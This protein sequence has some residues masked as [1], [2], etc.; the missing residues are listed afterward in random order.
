LS[1]FRS[2]NSSSTSPRMASTCRRLVSMVCG[3]Y[4]CVREANCFLAGVDA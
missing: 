1:T 4:A 3:K 2:A